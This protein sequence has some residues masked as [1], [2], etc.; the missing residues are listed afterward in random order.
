[1]VIGAKRMMRVTKVVY[2]SIS[3]DVHGNHALEAQTVC[4]VCVQSMYRGT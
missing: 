1:M 3:S 4:A 2:Y